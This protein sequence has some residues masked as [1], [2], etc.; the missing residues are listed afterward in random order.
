MKECFLKFC[1]FVRDNENKLIESLFEKVEKLLV[2]HEQTKS[3]L[4]LSNSRLDIMKNEIFA[5][6]NKNRDLKQKNKDLEMLNEILGGKNGNKHRVKLS[7][8]K[9]IRD[10]DLCIVHLKNN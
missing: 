5:M 1:I 9:L 6:S 2:K 8:N 10:I 4:E 3:E 7:L